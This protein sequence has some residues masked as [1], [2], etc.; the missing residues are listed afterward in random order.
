MKNLNNYIFVIIILLKFSGQAQTDKKTVDFNDIKSD[1]KW[2]IN[3]SEKEESPLHKNYIYIIKIS[4]NKLKKE[5]N[6]TMSFIFQ[7]IEFEFNKELLGFNKFFEIDNNFVI[8]KYNKS[9][10]EYFEII[11]LPINNL[12]DSKMVLDKLYK[13]EFVGTD[14]YF[15]LTYNYAKQNPL[16]ITKKYYENWY[17]VP[18]DKQIFIPPVINND[19]ILVRKNGRWQNILRQE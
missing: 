14:T 1:I 4:E 5:L 6:F 15:T 11:N 13:N 9:N 10:I 3:M 2:Y 7:T 19:S 12:N 8:M 16:I 18:L 17:D